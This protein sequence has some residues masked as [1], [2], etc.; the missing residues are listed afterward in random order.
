CCDSG[1]RVRPDE[2]REENVPVGHNQSSH[3]LADQG[4][5]GEPAGNHRLAGLA[6]GRPGPGGC[7]V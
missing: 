2:Q 3:S 1:N 5:G 7:A 4:H 6:G